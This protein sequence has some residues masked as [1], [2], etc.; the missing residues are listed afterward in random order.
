MVIG[1][2]P[3]SKYSYPELFKNFTEFI[4]WNVSSLVA[5]AE[6]IQKGTRFFLEFL[7]TLLM[8]NK[9]FEPGQNYAKF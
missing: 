5:L 9:S 1:I 4:I 6:K 8:N 3:V 2:P 7:W